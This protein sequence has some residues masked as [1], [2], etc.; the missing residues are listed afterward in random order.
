MKHKTTIPALT[1]EGFQPNSKLSQ[2]TA[3]KL[4]NEAT[5]TDV[6]PGEEEG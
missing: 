2:E 6:R 3:L 1:E 4:R 5:I